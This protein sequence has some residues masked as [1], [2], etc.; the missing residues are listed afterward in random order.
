MKKILFLLAILIALVSCSKDSYDELSANY[1]E[2]NGNRLQVN[3]LNIDG[4]Y[5]A[6]GSSENNHINAIGVHYKDSFSDIDYN[7]KVYF[8]IQ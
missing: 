6:I 1:I 7:K 3:Y 2:V 4:G 8:S 5:F